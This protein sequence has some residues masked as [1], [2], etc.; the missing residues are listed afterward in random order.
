V[1]PDRLGAPA[2]ADAKPDAVR[3]WAAAAGVDAVVIGR[4]TRIGSQLSID[5]RLCDAASGAVARTYVQAVPRQEQLAAAVD[6]LAARLLAGAAELHP[7][8]AVSAAPAAAGP[9]PAPT[10]PREAARSAPAAPASAFGFR[11]GKG[12]ALSIQSQELEAVE[13]EGVRVLRFRQNVRLTQGDMSI[14]AASLEAVYPKAESQPSRL[15]AEGGPGKQVEVAQGRQSARCNRATY[16]RQREWITCEGDAA[17]RDGDNHL[18]GAV[19][20]VDLRNET[21]HVKG[22]AAVTIQPKEAPGPAAGQ[23]PGA[24]GG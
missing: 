3:A 13:R 7:A 16:D 19:I 24:S 23:T 15:V 5:V 8:A 20:E 10:P 22:G 21:V 6:S 9:A 17:F 14:A 18:S 1:G 12:E 2:R 11:L 4:T